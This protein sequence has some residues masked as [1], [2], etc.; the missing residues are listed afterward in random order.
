MEERI[1]SILK[2]YP[3]TFSEELDIDLKSGSEQEIFKWFL[4]SILFGKRISMNIA[5]S[6]YQ[7][8]I[9]AHLSTPQA[10]IEAGWDKLVEILDQGGYVR[11]DFSTADK[12]LDIMKMLNENYS[13][14]ITNIHE[15]AADAKDLEVRLQKFKGI[16]PIT[17][18]IF[19]RELKG[20]WNKANPDLSP[21]V[22]KMAH[23]FGI[24]EDRVRS[25]IKLEAALVRLKSLKNL[26]NKKTL[27]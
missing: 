10:I 17:C 23:K 3:K 20:I 15:N 14:R 16:G 11:Y 2:M 8:F 24:D 27:I 9:N 25:D 19:L 12:L 18:N 21:L 5:Q 13:G 1:R 6:T 4:A 22:K 26:D 7:G